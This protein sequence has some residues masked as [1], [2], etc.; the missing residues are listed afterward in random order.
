MREV[1]EISTYEVLLC[2]IAPPLG[3]GYL[4]MLIEPSQPAFAA[5]RTQ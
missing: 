3:I 2:R 5:L 4:H 1:D